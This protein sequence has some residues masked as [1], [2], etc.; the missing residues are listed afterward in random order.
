MADFE[1]RK[2]RF[3]AGCALILIVCVALTSVLLFFAFWR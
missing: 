1:D 3:Y 2:A